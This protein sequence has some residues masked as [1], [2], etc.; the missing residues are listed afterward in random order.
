M[1]VNVCKRVVL[2]KRIGEGGRVNC[3]FDEVKKGTTKFYEEK[4][5][6]KNK[7]KKREK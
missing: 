5:V 4:R 2:V 3:L 1:R 7:K 6:T